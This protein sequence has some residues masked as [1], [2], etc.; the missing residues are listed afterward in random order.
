[1]QVVTPAASATGGN[2]VALSY[3]DGLGRPYQTVRTNANATVTITQSTTYDARG[4]VA[5]VSAPYG[6]GETPVYET[7]TYDDLDRVVKVT[8]ADGTTV[9]KAYG[10]N[11]VGGGYWGAATTTD[12]A[13][14]QQRDT[15]DAG[16]R[17]KSHDEW[18]D[19]TLVTRSYVY[20]GR[21]NLTSVTDGTHTW[22]Y[23]I[24][25]LGRKTASSDPDA[26]S[27]SY[28]YD[29]AGR[30]VAQTDALGQ[31]TTFAYDALGRRTLKTLL[32][33]TSSASTATWIY[34]Q[35]TAGYFN[36][37]RLT[38]VSDPSGGQAYDYDAL[39]R[40]V[41]STRTIGPASY[42]STSGFDASGRLLWET[43]PDGDTL[44]TAAAPLTYDDL[45]RPLS[46]PG[47]V[48]SVA[49]DARDHLTGQVNANGTTTTHSYSATRFW[50]NGIT[51][52]TATG[53]TTIQNL[54]FARD[55]EGKITQ[56]TSPFANEGWT[57]GY[58]QHRLTSATNATSATYNQT[59][60]YDLLGDITSNSLV[61]SYAYA[62][63]GHAHAVSAAGSTRYTYDANGAMLSGSAT[64][65]WNADR[66][67][68]TVNGVEF[69]YDADGN[70]VEKINTST[71]TTTYYLSDDYE[72]TGGVVTKYIS[73]AGVP[74]ARRVGTTTYWLHTDHHGSIQA[75]TD[76]AGTVQLRNTYMPFGAPIAENSSVA[77]SRSYTAQRQDETGLFYLHARYYDPLLAR[78]TSP[79]PTVPSSA[80]VGLNRYAYAF[81]DPV[82]Y[83]DTTGLFGWS[84]LNP[85]HIVDNIGNA[86]GGAARSIG[87]ALSHTVHDALRGI[88]Q[89]V[90]HVA[91][92]A[93]G[94][95]VIGGIVDAALALDPFT[96]LCWATYDSKGWSRAYATGVIMVAAA[97]L[98]VMSAGLA[99]PLMIA[100]DAAIGAGAGFATAEVNG[101]NG[102]QA[103][104]AAE[105][106]A[107]ISAACAALGA[108]AR[109]AAGN[110]I[111]EDAAAGDTNAQAAEADGSA[112]QY[113]QNPTAL[114]SGPDGLY[115]IGPNTGSLTTGAYSAF[116]KWLSNNIP[117]ANYWGTVQDGIDVPVTGAGT[118]V[119]WSGCFVA[120][121]AMTTGYVLASTGGSA[122]MVGDE[123]RTGLS[124][125]A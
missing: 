69:V 73:L 16:G 6:S 11:A 18:L 77:E 121:G 111:S 118:A 104:L 85:V 50:L 2:L 26:G 64:I 66:R 120:A 61:G 5:T 119:Y 20:D 86:L 62:A 47:V 24:D 113:A 37:G 58:D 65:T 94:I 48:S 78:F 60:T 57:Y 124:R 43:F 4:N 68:A 27:W 52:T 59:L 38:S 30:L 92:Q 44:G 81:N 28:G 99:A 107:A 51:T 90:E 56:L 31:T 46:I 95:P 14:H 116:S 21:G 112:A 123:A 71:G 82:D 87:N 55:A 34:D 17:T 9:S 97:V 83:T 49:Y 41:Q 117:F 80:T 67:P 102:S 91:D 29:N 10:F 98:T 7:R 15:F 23:A 13:G 1:M 103:L 54:G 42:P 36:V 106:G 96:G 108:A 40:P 63:A 79:D 125:V 75:E 100:A 3:L 88:G 45:G 12:E 93:A 105:R 39:G 110:G 35:S 19:G 101:A 109:A 84:D 74:V 114:G 76:A 22:S 89:S 8:H 33:G 122:F 32:A 115:T 70:R 72:I 25:S 53:P